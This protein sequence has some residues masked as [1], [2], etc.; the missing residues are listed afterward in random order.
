MLESI[1]LPIAPLPEQQEIVRR[2]EGMF[3]LADQLEL[4]FV[5]ARGQV[6][7]LTP[8][9]LARAFAGKLVPQ[10]PTDEPAS[11]LLERIRLNSKE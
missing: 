8:S 11:V 3:A 1:A 6:D 10:D 5:K 2:V 4:R 7:N 9:L